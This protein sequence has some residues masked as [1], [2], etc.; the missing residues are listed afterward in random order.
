VAD[1]TPTQAFFAER[2]RI[3][4]KL[5]KSGASL[6]EHQEAVADLVAALPSQP[7]TTLSRLVDEVMEWLRSGERLPDLACRA[8]GEI[9]LLYLAG[10]TKHLDDNP[11]YHLCAAVSHQQIA[12]V[13]VAPLWGLA[14]ILRDES[15]WA[16]SIRRAAG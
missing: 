10:L 5:W 8:E 16:E 3:Y 14:D 1:I 11:V 9:D 13:Q 6:A 7:Q 2:L 4:R 12:A 15:P